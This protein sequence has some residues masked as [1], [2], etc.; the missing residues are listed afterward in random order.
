MKN[1]SSNAEKILLLEN[2]HEERKT[3]CEAERAGARSWLKLKSDDR[4]IYLA[5][6]ANILFE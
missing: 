2:I 4:F 5:K 3:S 1:L 6:F